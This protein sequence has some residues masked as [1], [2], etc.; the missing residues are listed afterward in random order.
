MKSDLWLNKLPS[1][2]PNIYPAILAIWPVPALNP[3]TIYWLIWCSKRFLL[4]NHFQ[5]TTKTLLWRK[6]CRHSS[7]C[8]LYSRK[9]LMWD[10]KSCSSQI[11]V[12]KIFAEQELPTTM[13]P[14]TYKL[15][16]RA[17]KQC[18]ATYLQFSTC[19]SW[20]VYLP[21]GTPVFI[22]WG[23][24]GDSVTCW[25]TARLAFSASKGSLPVMS[26]NNR[27]PSE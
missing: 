23:W 10:W 26:W 11:V 22:S 18:V 21:S 4:I 1:L 20:I 3:L 25:N 17:T 6:R 12:H 13:A 7:N 9:E 8:I 27:M 5:T 15:A 2:F 24:G 16:I 19:L 14:K